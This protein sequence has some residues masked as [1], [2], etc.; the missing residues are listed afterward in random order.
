MKKVLCLSFL[1][2][3]LFVNNVLA[4]SIEIQ[5]SSSNAVKDSLMKFF[6]K[7]GAVVEKVTEYSLTTKTRQTSF[8]YAFLFGSSFNSFPEI[9]SHYNFVQNGKNTILAVNIETVTNPN[10]AYEHSIPLSDNQAQ[11]SLMQLKKAIEGFYGYGVDFK[12]KRKYLKITMV[13]PNG[14]AVGKL[15][16]GDRIYKINNEPIK[17]MSKADCFSKFSTNK[18]DENLVLIVGKEN[19]QEVI[20][21]S[22]FFKP[23]IIKEN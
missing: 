7:E 2:V 14:S 17:G 3:F 10:S 23:L 8:L 22:K 18:K 1:F 15:K 9:R 16:L 11:K 20:L 19:P 4:A 12:K 5:N 21:K 13:S 6:I